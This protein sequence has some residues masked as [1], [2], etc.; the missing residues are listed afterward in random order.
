M[1]GFCL[2]FDVTCGVLLDL[3][4]YHEF[5]P[6]CLFFSCKVFISCFFSAVEPVQTTPSN[7]VGIIAGVLGALVLI[8]IVIIAVL[9]YKKYYILLLFA[10]NIN[11]RKIVNNI[12][13]YNTWRY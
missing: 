1:C 2:I 12:I 3:R 4:R 5:L 10:V 6:D 8:V 13:L 7:N 11:G 9:L